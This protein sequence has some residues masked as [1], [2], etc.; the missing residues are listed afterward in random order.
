MALNVGETICLNILLSW[1]TKTAPPVPGAVP[2]SG[3]EAWKAAEKLLEAARKSGCAMLTQGQLAEH[4]PADDPAQAVLRTLCIDMEFVRMLR[5]AAA[6][7]SLHPDSLELRFAAE[8]IEDAL[9]GEVPR[10]RR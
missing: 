2:S 4:W 9:R 8:R 6:R 7:S 1:I 3:E 5:R 10:D